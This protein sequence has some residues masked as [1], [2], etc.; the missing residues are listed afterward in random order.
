[1]SFAMTVID[2]GSPV[3]ILILAVDLGREGRWLLFFRQ[4]KMVS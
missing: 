4:L 3:E 1:M 2:V